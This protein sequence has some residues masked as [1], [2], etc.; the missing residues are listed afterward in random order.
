[1]TRVGFEKQKNGMVKEY[2]PASEQ[3]K[4]THE[5]RQMFL[6]LY[7]A[8]MDEGLRFSRQEMSQGGDLFE[9]F[10]S[11]IEN[12]LFAPS[13]SP[14]EIPSSHTVHIDTVTSRKITSFSCGAYGYRTVK[15]Q[16]D[17]S[18]IAKLIS[19]V[20]KPDGWGLLCDLDDMFLHLVYERAKLVNRKNKVLLFEKSIVIQ[21]H[22]DNVSS[23]L[24][25]PTYKKIDKN[26]IYDDPIISNHMQTVVNT[27]KETEI[28][29]IYLVYPK[30]PEFKKYLTIK[31]LGEVPLK[32]DEYR[33]KVIPYSFSFC[34]RKQKKTTFK[35]RQKCQ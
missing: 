7:N 8:Y 25:I 34:T 10:R 26:R 29:Q 31:L 27:L 32:E 16:A 6:H 28:R 14:F 35:R 9:L 33:V 20:Y 19:L 3:M 18:Q 15:P 11:K 30:H 21:D 4:S 24:L 1:M 5:Q 17:L 12:M 22:R 23:T 2:L 13:L